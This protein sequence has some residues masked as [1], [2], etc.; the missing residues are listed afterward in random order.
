MSACEPCLSDLEWACDHACVFGAQGDTL[1][2]L[3]DPVSGMARCP[4]DPKHA[5]VALF[6]GEG[7][8][9]FPLFGFFHHCLIGPFSSQD[10]HYRESSGFYNRH[11]CQQAVT[12]IIVYNCS[13]AYVCECVC[14]F[15]L[16][17]YIH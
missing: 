7:R 6:A 5:N 16:F 12:V 17:I 4:Y 8:F 11:Y 3:G 14:V 13:V 1:E 10:K 15:N 2:M 9:V